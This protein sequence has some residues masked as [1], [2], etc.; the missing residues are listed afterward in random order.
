MNYNKSF[1]GVNCLASTVPW[2]KL[3]PAMQAA[4]HQILNCPHGGLMKQMCS[5]S[6]AIE[7]LMLQIAQWLEESPQAKLCTELQAGDV[8]RIY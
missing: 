4:P 7:L 5:E 6:N 8:E 3:T 1:K 2:A